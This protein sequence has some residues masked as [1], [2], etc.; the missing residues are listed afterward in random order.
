MGSAVILEVFGILTEI[1]K[2]RESISNSLQIA[3][4]K[5]K[6]RSREGKFRT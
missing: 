6:C 5:P 1:A 4:V 3:K 2:R